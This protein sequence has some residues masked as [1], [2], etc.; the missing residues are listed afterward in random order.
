MRALALADRPFHADAGVLAAQNELDAVVCL[1][2]LQTSWLETLDKVALPKLGQYGVAQIFL[3]KDMVSRSTS[4]GIIEDVVEQY[5]MKILGWR[6]VPT[7][8][9]FVGPT[10][11]K[12]EP[13]IRQCF[14]G[15]AEIA[16]TRTPCGPR[17]AA[18]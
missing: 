9:K 7:N 16:F 18:R 8:S 6:D 10:P 12:T 2:D 15:P 4:I 11:R 14:I 1:G 17:S 13:K 3:P 5:G